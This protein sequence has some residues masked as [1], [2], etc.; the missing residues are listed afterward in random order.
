MKVDSV[1]SLAGKNPFRKFVRGNGI[2][3]SRAMKKLNRDYSDWREGKMRG[4]LQ[5][6][7]KQKQYFV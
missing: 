4:E 7:F 2:L 3:P 6:L 5:H 1:A